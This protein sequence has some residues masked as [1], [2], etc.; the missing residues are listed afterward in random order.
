MLKPVS[1]LLASAVVSVLEESSELVLKRHYG[2]IIEFLI[3]LIDPMFFTYRII[4]LSIIEQAYLRK[5][6]DS[7]ISIHE[8]NLSN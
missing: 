6:I 3:S 7:T 1:A 2:I 5:T 8:I 4:D